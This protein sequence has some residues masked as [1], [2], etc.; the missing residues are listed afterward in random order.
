[1]EVEIFNMEIWEQEEFLRSIILIWTRARAME[2]QLSS[3]TI[4]EAKA[5][6]LRRTMEFLICFF[7]SLT[8]KDS[9]L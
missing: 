4:K 6:F 9:L 1:M 3:R 7:L 5:M 2:N 8:I